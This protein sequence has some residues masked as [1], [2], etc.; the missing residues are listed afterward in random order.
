MTGPHPAAPADGTLDHV[1]V[2]VLRRMDEAADLFAALGFQLTPRGHH[3]LGSINHLMMTAGPYLELVGVPETG[4]QRQDVLDSPFGLNGL[5]VASRDADATQGRLAAAGLAAGP[6]VAFSRP[7][8]VDGRE[9]EA[10]FR[11]VRVP[12]HLFPAGRLYHCEH[13]TPD[14][15]WRPEWLDHPNGFSGIDAL[16]IESPTPEADAAL[17]AAAC[18]ASAEGADTGWTIQLGD[19]RIALVPGPDARFAALALRFQRLD[20]LEARASAL[21]EAAWVR[22]GPDKATLTLPAFD[23]RLPCR[24][25]P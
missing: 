22:H 2:N 13:L 16:T 20:A 21:P 1:V 14:L 17:Y 4:P 8:T 3:S 15:V 5:V 10:R 6:P 11:T 24:A 23:L 25:A 12:A 9:D 18:G 19:T 7:V